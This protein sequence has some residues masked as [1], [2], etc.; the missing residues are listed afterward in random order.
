METLRKIGE[1]APV[2]SSQVG[3]STLGLGFEKLD[4]GL[5]DPEKAYDSV[6]ASG[7]KWVRIQ[8]G[9][10]RTEKEKGVY[11]FA[12][13]DSVVDNL[14][15]R[16][17]EPWMCLCYGNGLYSPRAAEVFGAV[18]CPPIES[19][20]ERRAWLNYVTATVK[21]FSG[22]IR[23]FEIWNEPDYISCWKP[24]VDGAAYGRFALETARA[25]REAAGG[26][27]IA[28]GAATNQDLGWV[29]DV[30]NTGAVKMFDAWSYHSYNVDER[31]SVYR[32]RAVKQLCLRANPDLVFFQGE[33]GAQ[34]RSDGAGGL[35]G[36]AWTPRRQAKFLSRIMLA[37]LCEEVQCN[38]FFSCMDMVEALDGKVGDRA[39]YMDY[40]YFGVLGADF[41]EN[42][43]AAGNFTPKPSYR[44]LQA[45]AAIFRERFTIEQLPVQPC[46]APVWS[47]RI[48]RHEDLFT[49]LI[50]QGFARPDGSMALA[51]WKP[52]ELLTTDYES[53]VSVEAAGVPDIPRVA[54]MLD[55]SI[56]EIP[57]RMIERSANGAMVLRN[58]PITDYPLLLTFGNFIPGGPDHD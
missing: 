44:A 22:R 34:S 5:F 28:G 1:V 41:D 24:G 40:G 16:G 7:V 53:T 50:M 26:V 38:S 43:I 4:R 17:L 9:W 31:V 58:L 8:S 13:L 32:V 33:T 12:W 54:D 48:A 36:H 30:I 56:Y 11:D 14:L 15:R 47:G 51:Y 52:A 23:W 19:E 27:R 21:H 10:A 46:W 18:G 20:E 42:G 57:E 6:A 45:L 2:S 29:T 3:T 55:G 49:D 35:A 37:H 25:I 39:S